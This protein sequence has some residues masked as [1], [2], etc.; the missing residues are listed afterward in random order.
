M[1]RFAQGKYTLKN[2]QKFV[3]NNLELWRYEQQR[4]GF[5]YRLSDVHAAL[6]FSQ[7]SRLDFFIKR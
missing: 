1:A 6:G 7:L 4:L 2:P 3:G 5:N